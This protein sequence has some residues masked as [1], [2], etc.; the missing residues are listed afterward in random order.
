MNVQFGSHAGYTCLSV[1]R[2]Y[3]VQRVLI[4][5]VSAYVDSNAALAAKGSGI[6]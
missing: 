1:S 4:D 5:A 3:A 6:N 2:T